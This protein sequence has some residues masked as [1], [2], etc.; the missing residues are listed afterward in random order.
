MVRRKKKAVKKKIVKTRQSKKV[1]KKKQLKKV[2]IKKQSK[3]SSDRIFNVKKKEFYIFL[4]MIF[5][6][7]VL[8]YLVYFYFYFGISAMRTYPE[9]LNY[10]ET[11]I[12]RLRSDGFPEGNYNIN[13]FVIYQNI[14]PECRSDPYCKQCEAKINIFEY[15]PKILA[16][17]LIDYNDQFITILLSS[18]STD[19]FRDGKYYQFSVEVLDKNGHEDTPDIILEGYSEAI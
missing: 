9:K 1:V 2:S 10:K 15:N 4:T 19:K 6:L 14:C 5:V 3:K 16:S 12:D 17:P 13:G 7:M 8:L 11:S 18:T